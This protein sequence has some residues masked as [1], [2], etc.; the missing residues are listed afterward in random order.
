MW[1]LFNGSN[2]T[3]SANELEWNGK[4]W[5]IVNHFIPFT[6]ADVGA[7]ERFNLTLWCN[8]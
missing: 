7:P 6:E 2:L 5:S 3:A 8:I 4:Q 1:M